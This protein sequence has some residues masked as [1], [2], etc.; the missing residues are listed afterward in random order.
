MS[1]TCL[2]HRANRSSI[3]DRSGL[4]SLSSTSWLVSLCKHGMFWTALN[5]LQNPT[6]AS[7]PQLLPFFHDYIQAAFTLWV[8]LRYHHRI[9]PFVL[10]HAFHTVGF[11]LCSDLRFNGTFPGNH[12]S[13][14]SKCPFSCVIFS[15]QLEVVADCKNGLTDIPLLKYKCY[16]LL[17]F[18]VIQPH[19]CS[20]NHTSQGLHVPNDW[21][22]QDNKGSFDW[23]V[24]LGTPMDLA[25]N[26]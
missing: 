9:Y 21:V 25:N 3:H 12:L 4:I 17:L 15:Q 20:R 24:G 8:T 6:T 19:T 10:L 7:C 5:C 13:L 26:L 1:A 23:H 16:A 22:R 11:S 14:S 2:F 18:S